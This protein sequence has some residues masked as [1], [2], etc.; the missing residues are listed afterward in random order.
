MVVI[1]GIVSY[2][3]KDIK[4]LYTLNTCAVRKMVAL[5]CKFVAPN[6]TNRHEGIS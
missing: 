4:L 2:Q 5:T 3:Y 1:W 6:H